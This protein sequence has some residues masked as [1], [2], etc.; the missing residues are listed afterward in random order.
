M[1]S[2]LGQ[3]VH[4]ADWDNTVN[5]ND[6]EIALIGGGSSGIQILPRVQ[7]IAKRVDHYMKGK[8]WISPIGAGFEELQARGAEGNCKQR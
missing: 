7:P 1:E 5:V 3:L 6:R 4:S 8:T 2:F